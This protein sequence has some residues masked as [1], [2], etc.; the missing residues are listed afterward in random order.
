MVARRILKALLPLPRKRYL[1]PC[2]NLLAHFGPPPAICQMKRWELITGLCQGTHSMIFCTCEINSWYLITSQLW[3]RPYFET[4][5]FHPLSIITLALIIS[6]IS[7]TSW[8]WK[9]FALLPSPFGSIYIFKI[10]VN[11][12]MKCQC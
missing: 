11:Y 6:I 4:Y 8:T 10:I 5:F 3:R 12:L 7:M 2:T 1:W 9:S